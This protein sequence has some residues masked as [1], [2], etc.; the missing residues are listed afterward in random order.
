MALKVWMGENLDRR[1][2][3]E[4]LKEFLTLMHAFYDNQPTTV[5]VLCNFICGGSQ[6]DAAVVK[7]DAFIPIEFKTARGP[8]SG[9]ENGKWRFEDPDTCREIQLGGGSHA[10]NPYNQVANARTAVAQKLESN[11]NVFFRPHECDRVADWRHFVHGLVVL[12]PNLDE[13]VSDEIDVDFYAKPWFDYCRIKDVAGVVSKTTTRDGEL[14][15]KN[16]IKI[17]SQVLHLEEADMRDGVPVLQG[18]A[19]V[20]SVPESAFFQSRSPEDFGQTLGDLFSGITNAETKKSA[21]EK[22]L[23]PKPAHMKSKSPD[24]KTATQTASVQKPPSPLLPPK[25][26]PSV[27]TGKIVLIDNPQVKTSLENINGFVCED[28]PEYVESAAVACARSNATDLPVPIDGDWDYVIELRC[29][30]D[31]KRALSAVNEYW[32]CPYSHPYIVGHAK[33]FQCNIMTHNRAE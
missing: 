4:Q 29:K 18:V 11:E 2:E 20:E 33:L 5:H 31:V 32:T 25:S 17:V 3:Q 14:S 15:N 23:P 9:S 8:V 22:T 6:I 16:I 30:G 19:D 28:L 27:V 24:V 13:G 12:A 7:P 26:A 1:H 21:L 10:S